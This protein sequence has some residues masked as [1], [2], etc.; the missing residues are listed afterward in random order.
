M[1]ELPAPMMSLE[2]PMLLSPLPVLLK[3]T[4]SLVQLP[5][6]PTVEMSALSVTLE[7]PTPPK[8]ISLL[9]R[10]HLSYPCH[11]C[12]WNFPPYLSCSLSHSILPQTPVTNMSSIQPWAS[13]VDQRLSITP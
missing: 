8:L 3:L 9:M 13:Q 11:S 10:C 2:L 5:A 6:P 4:T 12:R 1:L 7:L